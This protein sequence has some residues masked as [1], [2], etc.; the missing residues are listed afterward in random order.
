MNFI[1]FILSTLR[2]N[3][4]AANHLITRERTKLRNEQKFLKFQ[5]EIMTLM[6]SANHIGSDIEFIL[7]RRS[8]IYI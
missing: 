5:F 8:Y 2:T 1:L 7:R 4:L 6:S 3:L